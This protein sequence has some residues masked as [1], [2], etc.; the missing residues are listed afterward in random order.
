MEQITAARLYTLFQNGRHLN[1]LLFLFKLALDASFLKGH[2]HGRAWASFSNPKVQPDFFKFEV[3]NSKWRPRVAAA[4]EEK[5]ETLGEND[6][7]IPLKEQERNGRNAGNAY[8]SNIFESIEYLLRMSLRDSFPLS[9]K[10]KRI[11]FII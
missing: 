7:S 2:C 8:I 6:S 4:M 10:F 1:I 9:L 3:L 11:F 5:E